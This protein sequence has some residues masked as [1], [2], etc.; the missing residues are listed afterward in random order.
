VQ[1]GRLLTGKA[2]GVDRSDARIPML[3]AGYLGL[4]S[5]TVA[6]RRAPRVA[7]SQNVAPHRFG[8]DATPKAGRI[9]VA[10][11]GN[12]CLV[13]PPVVPFSQQP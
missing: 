2:A 7:M 12:T 4:K 1:D 8:A 3:R 9:V 5:T 11:K 6:A 13:A 10:A